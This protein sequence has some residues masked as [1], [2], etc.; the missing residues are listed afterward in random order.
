[1]RKIEKFQESCLRILFDFYESNYDASLHKSGKSI[2]EVKRLRSLAI[3]LFKT[4][5]N[6]NHSFMKEIFYR[7]PYVSHKKQNLFLQSRE[8]AGF[9]DGSPKRLVPQIYNS[10][11]EKVK[12]VT[13]FADFKNSVKKWFGP[14]CMCNLGSFKIK[15]Q[16]IDHK[17]L[18]LHAPIIY[19][20]SPILYLFNNLTAL[21]KGN[22]GWRKLGGVLVL[23]RLYVRF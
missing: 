9:G 18:S 21:V 3:E 4:L 20:L 10:L 22:W 19:S 5:N 7:Y 1:M 17:N 8:T 2:M 12:S 23:I 11:P 14:K 6:Q 15:M 13:N 16:K